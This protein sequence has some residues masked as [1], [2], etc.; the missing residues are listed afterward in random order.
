MTREA[1]VSGKFYPGARGE[2]ESLLGQM[3]AGGTGEK[4]KAIGVICPHAGYMFSGRVAGAVYSGVQIPRK[5]ILIGP[6]HTGLGPQFSIMT[7]GEWEVPNG[8]LPVDEELAARVAGHVPFFTSDETAHAYEHSIE[9]QLPFIA[10]L[11]PDARIVP[12]V[13][14]PALI[15]YLR[16]AAEGVARTVED[17]GGGALI[18]ASSDMSHYVP[19]ETAREK[20][21][22]AIKHILDLDPAGLYAEAI[23]D[24]VSMCGLPAVVTTLYAA[25]LLGASQASLAAYATSGDVTGD[26]S[27]VVGYAGI[28]IR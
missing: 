10:H 20:D 1:A 4:Q 2:L 17:A 6:N 11:R 13:M 8:V 9:V 24:K 26:R 27:Q 15:D 28:V 23:D 5:V 16:K 14:T 3:L 19:E 22:R 12:I 25:I 18:I 21:G 7:E